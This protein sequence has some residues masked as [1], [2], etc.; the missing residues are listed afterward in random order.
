MELGKIIGVKGNIDNVFELNFIITENLKEIPEFKAFDN[1]ELTEY[2]Y[3]KI[4][5]PNRKPVCWSLG[6]SYNGQDVLGK[7]KEKSKVCTR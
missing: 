6:Y 3:S 2:L 5:N 4:P 1:V 7:F